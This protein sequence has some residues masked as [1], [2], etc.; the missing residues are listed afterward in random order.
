[1]T[2][3]AAA[4]G[5]SGEQPEV[6]LG[7]AYV[8]Q[9]RYSDAI[10]TLR[11]TIAKSENPDEARLEL[12]I[13]YLKADQAEQARQTFAAIKRDSDWRDLAQLWSLHAQTSER[14]G[15]SASTRS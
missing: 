7:R 6:R 5:G 9:G 3:T 10:A 12:G 11:K 4:A 8:A 15:K 14:E 13:P 2:K 1:M